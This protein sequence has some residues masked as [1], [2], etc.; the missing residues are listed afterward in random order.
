MQ[1]RLQKVLQLIISH[2]T[3]KTNFKASLTPTRVDPIGEVVEV[4]DILID[5]HTGWDS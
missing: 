1:K 2:N 3:G 5:K 4:A